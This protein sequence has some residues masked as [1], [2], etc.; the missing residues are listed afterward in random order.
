MKFFLEKNKD[1]S[2]RVTINIP[3]III[4]NVLIQEFYKI[5][6]KTNINGFRKGK[7][8]IKIIQQKYG[9]S[10]YY[11]VFNKLMK[12]FFYKFIEKEKINII[13]FPKYHISQNFIDTTKNNSNFQYFVTYEV[14][15]DIKIKNLNLIQVER[16]IVNIN[17]ED[18][19]TK[20]I[21]K[22]NEVI[23]WYQVNRAIKINDRVTIN[24]SIYKNNK[25]IEKFDITNMKFI[26]SKN[27]LLSELN[28]KIINHYTNDIIFFNIFFSSFHPEKDLNQKN[29]TFKI[30]I[31][32]IE[33]KQVD[34]KKEKLFSNKFIELNFQSI[35]TKIIKD[36]EKFTY[37]NLKNNIIKKLIEENPIAIPKKL[38]QEEVKKL[39]DQSIQE[40][41]KVKNILDKK[42]QIDF[43]KQAKKILTIKLIFEKIIKDNNITLDN[44]RV[45]KTIQNISKKYN[46]PSDIINMYK[47]N[48]IFRNAIK[49]LELEKQV[50]DFLIKNIKIIKKYYNFNEF[51]NYNLNLI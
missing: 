30:K 5:N 14:Y 35:K 23:T 24:C 12:Q 46:K 33:E 21:Q 18:I 9:D 42:Y 39:H 28:H 40:Y 32:K 49:D 15:P 3:K 51:L 10:V 36:V 50:L 26:V 45:E 8:P 7:A 4:D 17:D 31:I 29:I 48:K 37:N 34:Q 13:G 6:Q 25:K 43:K 41:K 20:I 22:K 1:E 16:M 19:K 11:D 2:Y 27:N 44:K 47:K 38:L